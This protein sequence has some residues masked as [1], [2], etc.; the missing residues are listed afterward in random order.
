[1]ADLGEYQFPK[2]VERLTKLN[3]TINSQKLQLED[4]LTL[5]QKRSEEKDRKL[6]IVAHDLRSPIASIMMLSNVI[7]KADNK[8]EID[9]VLQFSCS[10][11]CNNSLTL[12][13]R[14]FGSSG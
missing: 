7:K 1:M 10:T 3:N 11:A 12:I 14:N 2:N 5:V 4:A 6:H 9:K 8:E 13:A